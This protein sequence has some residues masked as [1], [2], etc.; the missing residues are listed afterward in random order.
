MVGIE[1]FLTSSTFGPVGIAGVGD[2][3]IS[4]SL[5]LVGIVG[6]DG[7]LSSVGLIDVSRD[8]GMMAEAGMVLR[9]GGASDLSTSISS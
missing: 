9:G 1:D 5:D 6:V 4:S 3:L 7:F 2:F 8:M